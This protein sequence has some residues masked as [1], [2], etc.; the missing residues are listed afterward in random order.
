MAV[1]PDT[2]RQG[3][4]E[5]AGDG[6]GGA[7]LAWCDERS[8]NC[9]VFAQKIT[10]SGESVWMTGG[11]VV[12][13]ARG[14]RTAPAIVSD[15]SGGA[16]IVWHDKRGANYDIFAQKLNASGKALWPGDGIVVSVANGDQSSPTITMDGAGGAIVAWYDK[17][18]GDY[19]IYAQ[20]ISAAGVS[21]WFSGGIPICTVAGDQMYPVL[22]SDGSGGAIVSWHDNRD[23]NY[24]IYAERIDASGAI[25]WARDG[26]VVC[27]APGDQACPTIA[28]DGTG[29]AIISWNDPRNIRGDIY[30][31]RIDRQGNLPVT[32]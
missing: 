28:A 26:L 31:Q 30:A 12:C 16:I 32:R 11:V 23:S 6:A 22:V 21:Q 17:R 27:A 13:K 7:V 18:N 4:P 20:K 9:E 1:C 10:S 24:D 3:Y 19:D 29:G 14:G 25:Q 8:G 15:G 5:L 2:L